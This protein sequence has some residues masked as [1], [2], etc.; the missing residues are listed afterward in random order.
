[1][2]KKN[3]ENAKQAMIARGVWPVAEF[4]GTQAA[5]PCR[6]M[7]CGEYVTPRYNNT[8]NKKVGGCKYCGKSKAAAAQQKLD[9]EEAK[10]S[11]I[12][13]GV[14]P[15][16]PYVNTLTPWPCR[17][18]ACGEY[19]SPTYANVASKGQGGC[20]PCAIR[21][22]ML[23]S[24]AAKQEMVNRGVWPISAFP[25]TSSKWLC[26]CMA[27]GD[28]VKTSYNSVVHHGNGG[29]ERC[30][31]PDLDPDQATR[32]ML[33]REL[34]PLEPFPGTNE[35]WQCKCTVCDETVAPYHASVKW[36]GSGCKYCARRAVNPQKIKERMISQG[37][38]PVSTFTHTHQPWLCVCM[39]C[40]DF[41]TPRADTILNA[42]Q[43]GC[44]NC[45][46]SGFKEGEP[47]IVYLMQN[48]DLAAAKVGI[49]NIGT[50]RIRK[51]ERA[52]WILY[53]TIEFDTGKLA[54]AVEKATVAVWRARGWEPVLGLGG[55]KYDGF[56]ET[57]NIHRK[58]GGKIP[59]SAL[60]ADVVNAREAIDYL[61][62]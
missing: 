5:W 53:D 32:D 29:C 11:M 14:W 52:G 57:V 1:M 18:M 36:R 33:A 44:Q 56:T 59:F 9:A 38:W 12:R 26:V 45:A 22:R 17:C 51:H 60:W 42:R 21:E 30:G 58:D 6:C 48:T 25:N 19:V 61:Q 50:G 8:V 46:R 28:F 10:Q 7:T 40:G 34:Q 55:T 62:R 23:D 20:A 43:G 3:P 13:R 2:P 15:V 31:R 27:C 47:A 54:L 16:A 39:E 37:Y 4:P 49:C 35:P 41:V 24:D